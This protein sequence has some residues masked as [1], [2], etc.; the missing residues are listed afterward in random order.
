MKKI[1][2]MIA[3]MCA[4]WH[5]NAQNKISGF[6]TDQN[7][8]PLFGAVV[9]IPELNKSTVSDSK[10]YYE[11]NYIPNG[12]LKIQCSYMGYANYIQTIH[13]QGETVKHN[14]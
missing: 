8:S 4:I 7:K 9:Y 5:I 14:I 10:G 11:I 12:D 3:F 1:I 2:L 6:I 13:L